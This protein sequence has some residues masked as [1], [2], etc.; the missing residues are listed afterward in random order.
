MNT[1]SISPPSPFPY[2]FPHPLQGS[3]SQHLLN[4]QINHL[5]SIGAIEPVPVYLRSR[6]SY[7]CYF[8]KKKGGWRPILDLRMLN[9][10]IKAEKFKMVMLS[11]II[12][13]LEKEDWFSALDLQDAYFSHLDHN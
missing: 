10:F 8:L 5:F 9:K 4:Q 2:P 12:P 7:S 13:A 1:A 6:G 3:F 11:T